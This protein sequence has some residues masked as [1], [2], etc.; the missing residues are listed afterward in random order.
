MSGLILLRSGP[1]AQDSYVDRLTEVGLGLDYDSM[2]L[3][4]TTE[5]WLAAGVELQGRVARVL[6]GVTTHVEV[7]GSS[8]VLDLLAKPIIDLAVGLTIDQPLTPTT[9]RLETDGWIYRGDAGE[10]GGH[11]FVLE[12]RPR[13]RVAHLHVVRYKS[14][15]WRDYLRFRDLLRQSPDARNRYEAVKVDLARREPVDRKAYTIGKTEVVAS[16]LHARQ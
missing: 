7:I 8:S 1:A 10:D 16:L 9:T 2:T 15:F 14:K 5:A 12:A 4:R 3:G 11:V 6:D 13:H